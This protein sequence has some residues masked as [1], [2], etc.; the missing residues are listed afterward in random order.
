M[1]HILCEGGDGLGKNT[2]IT[3]LCKHYSFDNV[4]VRHF[5]KPPRVFEEDETALEFQARCF[6]KEGQ[7]L[8]TIEQLENDKYG[9]YENTVIWNRSHLGEGVYGQMFRDQDKEEIQNFLENYEERFLLS[10]PETYLIQLTADP[11]FFLEREDGNSFS[12][13]LEEKTQELKLF[14]EMFEKSLIDKKLKINVC[15][16][17]RFL[18]KELVFK[19]ALEF[20]TNK[21]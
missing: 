3:S 2:L 5:G 13:S 7:L 17:A 1:K 6:I 21:E 8:Q 19:Q 14:D 11:D 12:Q 15:Q 18:P 20:I 16:N 10:N 4:M 9:Y